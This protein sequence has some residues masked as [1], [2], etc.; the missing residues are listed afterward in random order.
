MIPFNKAATILACK[1]FTLAQLIEVGDVLP[2][3]ITREQVISGPFW[4]EDVIDGLT[5]TPEDIERFKVEIRRRR[6]E[7]FKIE[8]SDVLRPH[9][10]PGGRG[11][12]F[13]PGWSDI[14]CQY[15]DRLR[16]WHRKGWTLKLVWGKEKFGSLRLFTDWTPNSLST[17]QWHWLCSSNE[18]ARRKS[19]TVC[20]Q[21]G[22]PGRVRWGR[23]VETLCDRHTHLVGGLRA[24]DGIVL[25]PDRESLG[26]DGQLKQRPSRFTLVQLEAMFSEAADIKEKTA[27]EFD[28]MLEAGAVVAWDHVHELRRKLIDVDNVIGNLRIDF[29]LAR[30]DFDAVEWK[31]T[32]DPDPPKWLERPT[33][34]REKLAEIK[35][36]IDEVFK[37]ELQ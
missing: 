31:I 21:C 33:I 20:D 12:E 23:H 14:L 22:E 30:F 10:G 15:C 34:S 29:K 1:P 13:S 26:K 27:L 32:V 6:F 3:S 24:E 11:L 4:G 19:L 9:T 37:G 7:D 18:L 17:L 8:Y 25:D 36:Q 35:A 16:A 28:P 2:H 5:F